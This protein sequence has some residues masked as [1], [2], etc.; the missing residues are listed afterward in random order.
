MRK[1][2]KFVKFLL[3]FFFTE[4]LL[5]VILILIWININNF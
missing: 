5:Y 2:K 1:N 4:Y 3:I